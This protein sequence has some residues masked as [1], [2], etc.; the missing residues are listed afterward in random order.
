[1]FILI[2]FI[3]LQP[4]FVSTRPSGFDESDWLNSF[5]DE[6]SNHQLIKRKGQAGKLFVD[7]ISTSSS[8][9]FVISIDLGW[10]KRA[11]IPSIDDD[12]AYLLHA[13]ALRTWWDDK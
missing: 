4:Q 8:F 12:R 1:M 5:Q 10:G 3:L 6:Q 13:A 2:A 9:S 7:E 11:Y